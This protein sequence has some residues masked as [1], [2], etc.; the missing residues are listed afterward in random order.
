MVSF[1]ASCLVAVVLAVGA[2]AVLSKVQAPSER[3]FASQTGVRI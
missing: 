3:A 1:I 2:A